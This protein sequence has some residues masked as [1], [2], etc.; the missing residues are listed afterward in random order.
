MFFLNNTDIGKVFGVQ[1]ITSDAMKGA[2]QLWDS[3]STGSPPWLD[4]EDGIKTVNMAKRFAAYT[5]TLTTLGIGVA[6][7]GSARADYIQEKIPKLMTR[8]RE[9]LIDA[10]RVGGMIIKFNGR[11]WDFVLNGDCGV[12]AKDDDGQIT[13]AIFAAQATQ[14]GSNYTRLEYHRFEKDGLYYV[15][16]RAFKNRFGRSDEPDLGKEVPLTE[17]A[18]WAEMIPDTPGIANLDKPLFGYF[19]VPGSNTTDPDSPLGV[20]VFADALYELESI[21][22]AI[23]RKDGEVKNSKHVTFV[24]Q[25]L[26]KNAK[27]KEVKLPSFVVGLGIGLN[28]TETKAIHEH[29][30]TILTKDRLDDINFNLSLAG[31]QCGFSEGVFVMDGQTGV[32]TATQVESDDRDTIQTIKHHREALQAAVEDAIYGASA[33]MTLYKQAPLGDYEL[34]FDFDD[35]TDSHEED[36]QTWLLLVARKIIPAWKYLERFEGFSEDEAK[37]LTAEAAAENKSKG[38]FEVE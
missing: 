17:V 2:V 10:E 1:L 20:A 34:T 5:A 19:R 27:K 24:G 38:L 22:I 29:V 28:D 12:T 7:D 30:P 26:V 33:L 14:N 13:G 37:A 9:K 15:S 25:A 23:S 8:L 36:K 3:V 35:I 4:P 16:N 31:V 6:C 11:S 18:E 32:I 21:D